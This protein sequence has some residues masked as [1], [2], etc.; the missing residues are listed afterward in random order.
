[1]QLLKDL[2]IEILQRRG[3]A[4]DR[5]LSEAIYGSDRQHQTINGECRHLA[6]IG[7]IV[8]SKGDDGIIRNSLA[9]AKAA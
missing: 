2:I 3:M 7:L 1:M 6:N 4:T 8:R 9:A 5:E